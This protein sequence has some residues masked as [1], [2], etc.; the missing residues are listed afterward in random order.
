MANSNYGKGKNQATIE[1]LKDVKVV[2]LTRE[3]I[4]DF[5]PYRVR[6][7]RMAV[8]HCLVSLL[9]QINMVSDRYIECDQ[10]KMYSSFM[11]IKKENQK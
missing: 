10:W 8:A 5:G 4:Y 7:W 1:V 3:L 6:S 2:V 9:K 11:P